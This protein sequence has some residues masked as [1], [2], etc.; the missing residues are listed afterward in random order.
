MPDQLPREEFIQIVRN[1]PLVAIDFVLWSQDDRLLLGRRNNEPAKGFLFVPGG[2][3]FKDEKIADAFSRIMAG[4]MGLSYRLADAHYLGVFE[5][6]YPTN[7]FGLSGFGTHYVVNAYE[8]R[9]AA[10]VAVRTEAQHSEYVWMPA[11]EV[12][13]HPEVHTNTKAYLKAHRPDQRG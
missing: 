6:F 8:I 10:D 4:E 3:I 13:S 1:T 11:A 7:V 12:L 2:R 5:H 9:L